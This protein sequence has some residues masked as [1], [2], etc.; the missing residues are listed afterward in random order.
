MLSSPWPKSVSFL[1]PTSAAVL[2]FWVDSRATGPSC[3]SASPCV[4]RANTAWW[5]VWTPTVVSNS[6]CPFASCCVKT[7]PI[8][9]FQRMAKF[10]MT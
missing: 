9:L 1:C 3:A 7:P 10:Q 8:F 5:C 4:K 6:K 2:P